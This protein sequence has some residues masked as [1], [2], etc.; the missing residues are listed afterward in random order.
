MDL[1][2]FAATLLPL[3]GPL[4]E[5]SACCILDHRLDARFGCNGCSQVCRSRDVSRSFVPDS[6]LAS[7]EGRL[8][9]AVLCETRE[10]PFERPLPDLVVDLCSTLFLKDF[11]AVNPQDVVGTADA[12]N[13]LEGGRTLS[14][15][16]GRAGRARAL[17]E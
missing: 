1:Q 17:R 4:S 13:F 6:G 9:H 16:P 3:P 2:I 11:V 15:D 12:Q 8:C 10:E 7:A 14:E 5:F